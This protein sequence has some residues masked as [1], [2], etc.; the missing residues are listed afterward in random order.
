MSVGTLHP[1]FTP[2]GR[3]SKARGYTAVAHSPYAHQQDFSSDSA[4][5]PA[6]ASNL[7]RGTAGN[8][9][10]GGMYMT[11]GDRQAAWTGVSVFSIVL[12]LALLGVAIATLVVVSHS[13]EASACHYGAHCQR[14]G[15]IDNMGTCNEDGACVGESRGQCD[16]VIDLAPDDCRPLVYGWT[17][18]AYGLA[19]GS[20]C[21]NGLCT[22]VLEAGLS[23]DWVCPDGAP[24]GARYELK[25]RATQRCR[26]YVFED[27]DYTA[28]EAFATCIDSDPVC[29][30]T[31]RDA[32]YTALRPT[33]LPVILNNNSEPVGYAPIAQDWWG[34][35]EQAYLDAKRAH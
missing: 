34:D 18:E 32:G 26:D 30:Y 12:L 29:V 33:T 25:A 20:L 9:Q 8:A 28:L 6:S 13:S 21:W 35:L 15:L 16:A 23:H 3:S 17:V 14:F 27:P 5:P 10:T 4:A 1:D 31:Y 24:G 19:N 7:E 2:G 22:Y 11:D